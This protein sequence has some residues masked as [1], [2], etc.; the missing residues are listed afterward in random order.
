MLTYTLFKRYQAHYKAVFPTVDDVAKFLE[1]SNDEMAKEIQDAMKCTELEANALVFLLRLHT[2]KPD[3]KGTKAHYALRKELLG[4]V[5]GEWHLPLPPKSIEATRASINWGPIFIRDP[6]VIAGNLSFEEAQDPQQVAYAVLNHFGIG[7]MEDRWDPRSKAAMVDGKFTD[8]TM[9]LMVAEVYAS[10]RVISSGW[11]DLENGT[12]HAAPPPGVDVRSYQAIQTEQQQR[13]AEIHEKERQERRS[14]SIQKTA[15]IR[16]LTQRQV[17]RNLEPMGE[18]V[19]D[20]LDLLQK[21]DFEAFRTLVKQEDWVATMGTSGLAVVTQLKPLVDVSI[22]NTKLPGAGHFVAQYVLEE[23]N[24]TKPGWVRPSKTTEELIPRKAP[25]GRG[26]NQTPPSQ[27]RAVSVIDRKLAKLIEKY[28]HDTVKARAHV[29]LEGPVAPAVPT[30]AV[31]PPPPLPPP[32]P[33]LP[34]P[35]PPPPGIGSLV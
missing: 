30:E 17:N 3:I 31:P 9:C 34:P 14:R 13:D 35:P 29:M 12:M 19:K 24:K 6:A 8:P 27:K 18:L 7:G 15:E 5:S 10:L 21:L 1:K 16:Q 2:T 26:N 4:T 20:I 23:F 22:K 28:G 25:L 32:P 33:P 11:F